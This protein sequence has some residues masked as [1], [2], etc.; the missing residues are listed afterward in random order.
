MGKKTCDV[1]VTGY[2]EA[3]KTEWYKCG[4]K[5]LGQIA[6]QGK[7]MLEIVEK[8]EVPQE[9]HTA[10]W[11]AYEAGADMGFF[12]AIGRGNDLV[13]KRPDTPADTLKSAQMPSKETT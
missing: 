4:G 13:N 1:N 11:A 8:Y 9:Y 12:K 7:D 2:C 3:H 5:P 6:Q 10:L